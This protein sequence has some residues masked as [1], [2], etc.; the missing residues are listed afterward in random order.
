[1]PEFLRASA[2]FT[3]AKKETEAEAPVSIGRNDE[4]LFAA[5]DAFVFADDAESVL[6]LPVDGMD[7]RDVA[8][9]HGGGDGGVSYRD[10]RE[11]ARARGDS[12]FEAGI[13]ALRVRHGHG[14]RDVRIESADGLARRAAGEKRGGGREGDEGG[15]FHF[16]GI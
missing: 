8:V 16:G 9:L 13:V 2:F 7:F 10:E 3:S 1:M 4:G 11:D 5:D 14:K 6:S 12:D 15:F